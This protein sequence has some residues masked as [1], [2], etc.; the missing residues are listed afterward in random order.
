M[1]ISIY[2]FAQNQTITLQTNGEP[3][4][5]VL[6]EISAKNK[7]K[8]AFDSDL[9]ETIETHFDLKNSTVNNFLNE[10][11]LRYFIHSKLIDGTW[12]L[13]FVE[14]QITAP[15]SPESI[16]DEIQPVK[17]QTISGFIKDKRTAEN[18]LY[19]NVAFS[20]NRGCMTNDLGFFSFET[21]ETDSVK[22][23]ISHLGYKRL[24]TVISSTQTA[25]IWLDPADILMEAIEIKRFEK[26]ILQAA[27]QPEK[28]GFNPLKANNTPKISSDDLLNALLYI[29]GID[30]ISGGT[31]GISIRGGD[32]NDNLILFDG[33]PVLETSHLLGNMSVLN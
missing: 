27:P 5:L 4:D 10:L 26:Q 16:V 31:P 8:F 15:E 11:K 13:V 3:L 2:S 20:E 9:F 14:P 29:P 30:F 25:V 17:F 24:D 28:I 21:E 7:L 1:V 22:L 32:P 19:C 18:L 6:E 23:M 12:V 33:I